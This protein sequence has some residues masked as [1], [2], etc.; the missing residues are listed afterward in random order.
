M[1]SETAVSV[2]LITIA[3]IALVGNSLV[4]ILFIKNR[5]W[6]KKA[7]SCLILALAIQDILTAIGLL[8]LPGFVQ[9]PDAY[10]VPTSPTWRQLYCSMVWS[11]YFPFALAITSVYTCL[12][13]TIDRWFAVVKPLTYITLTHSRKA[14]SIMVI[15]PWIAGFLFE[16]GA[17][18]SAKTEENIDGSYKCTWKVIESSAGKTS[19]AIFSFLGMIFIPAVLI[20]VAYIQIVVRFK[21]SSSRVLPGFPAP[22]TIHRSQRQKSAGFAALKRLTRMA[23]WASAIVIV[24]W[25]PDQVFY[26]CFQLNIVQFGTIT[27]YAVMILAFANSCL[28]PVLYSF[29]NKQY[30]REFKIILCFLFEKK[31]PRSDIQRSQEVNPIESPSP[32]WTSPGFKT[33]MTY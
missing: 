18:L 1:R 10:S 16:I 24:C 9:P 6:L 13:L 14:T 26:A 12:M 28:N 21:A 11:Q 22:E 2:L 20:T 7:H 8:V 25:L 23:F 19:V 30:R 33:A 4:V 15:I 27:H 17:P 31:E 32:P 3:V 29:S 5:K